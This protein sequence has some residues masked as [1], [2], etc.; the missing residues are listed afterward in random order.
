MPAGL[1]YFFYKRGYLNSFMVEHQQQ[2]HIL[3]ITIIIFYYSTYMLFESFS[4]PI[5]LSSFVLGAAIAIL[6]LF[7]ANFFSKVSAHMVGAGGILGMLYLVSDLFLSSYSLFLIPVIILS[8]IIA[9]SRLKLNAH[10]PSEI[11]LGLL[12]GFTAEYCTVYYNLL[13]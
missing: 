8:G 11:Y 2:R 4:V 13:Y 5:I 3:Y 1:I 6:I 10:N 9:F 7:I 12:I